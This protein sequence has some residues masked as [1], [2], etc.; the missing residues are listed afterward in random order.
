MLGASPMIDLEARRLADPVASQER[1]DAGRGHV[2]GDTLEDVRTA[3]ADVDVVERQDGQRAPVRRRV[4][5]VLLGH[6]ASPR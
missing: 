5:W 1:R 2:E 6:S 3:V 4:G